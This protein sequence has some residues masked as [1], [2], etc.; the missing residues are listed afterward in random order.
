ML[1]G[2]VAVFVSCSEKFKEPVAWPVRDALAEHGLRGIIVSDEPPLPGTG[3]HAGPIMVRA[4]LRL[5]NA[6]SRGYHL[7]V[8]SQ[9]KKPDP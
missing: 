1:G 7:L 4:G 5:V 6:P 8:A 3:E 2:Q 9:W